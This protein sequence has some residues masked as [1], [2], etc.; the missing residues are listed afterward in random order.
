[1][2]D[3]LQLSSSSLSFAF[4]SPVTMAGRSISLPPR[5]A[6]SLLILVL[7]T[8]KIE[9]LRLLPYENQALCGERAK[10]WNTKFAGIG[11]RCVEVTGDTEYTAAKF[12]EIKDARIV[13]TTPEKWDAFTRW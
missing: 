10:D 6:S 13:V 4:S 12:K 8:T 2:V 1:M 5:Y 3:S 9:L 7:Q 11:V